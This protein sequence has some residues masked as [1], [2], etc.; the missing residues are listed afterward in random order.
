MDRD[1][2]VVGPVID[3]EAAAWAA[4][5]RGV[6]TLAVVDDNDRSAGLIPAD[7]LFAVLLEEHDEDMARLGG[8]SK[9]RRGARSLATSPQ[10]SSQEN[11]E[12]RGFRSCPGRKP[13][14]RSLSR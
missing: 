11:P 5:H 14:L 1:P 9:E 3:Q 7:R 13:A 8:F 10:R 6:S 2:R 12:A 4:V